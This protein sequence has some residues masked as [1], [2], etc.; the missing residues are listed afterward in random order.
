MKII[1]AKPG[2]FAQVGEIIT[3]TAERVPP[4]LAAQGYL[5]CN[6]ANVRIADYPELF[7]LIGYNYG[8]FAITVPHRFPRLRKLF[9]LPVK[10]TVPNPYGPPEGFF[11]L[12]D[13]R[14]VVFDTSH[15][16]PEMRAKIKGLPSLMAEAFYHVYELPERNALAKG[17]AFLNVDWFGGTY[18]PGEDATREQIETMLR[19]KR[20]IKPGKRYL[21][22]GSP[23]YTF[24][25]EPE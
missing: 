8:H 12:P 6:G 24:V 15:L 4:S 1:C 3:I 14:P 7:E 18:A 5:A 25:L 20:Y 19:A 22:L 21:V 23:G 17:F 9:G 10:Y 13:Y 2:P 16:S 11:Q